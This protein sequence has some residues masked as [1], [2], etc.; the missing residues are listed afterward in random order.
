MGSPPRSTPGVRPSAG[1]ALC[2]FNGARFLQAQLDSLSA[3]DERPQQ[4]V[5]I[6]D[7]SSDGSWELLQSW[8]AAAAGQVRVE[9]NA[10]RMGVV[11]NFEK[12]LSM[13]GTD[14]VFPCDQDD[15]WYPSKVRRFINAFA[16]DPQLTLLHGDADLVGEAGDALGW[17]LFGALR[18]TAQEQEFIAQ[19]QAWKVYARRNLVTGA[20]SAFRRQLLEIST[21]FSLDWVHDEWLGFHAALVGRVALC[22]EPMMAYRLHGN[23][24]V[25]LPLPTFGWWMRS[26]LQALLRPTTARQRWRAQR[27]DTMTEVARKLCA[28]SAAIDHLSMAAA[29]ARFR[30]G[31]PRNFAER[32]AGITRGCRAGHYHAWSNGPVSM[33]H[34]L[35]I[36]W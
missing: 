35:L 4:I 17:K 6:D 25:G 36:P 32:L 10:N 20:A 30:G 31:L 3:Q 14:I 23:N 27:L 19:G 16:Q 7:G 8:A 11:R 13:L 33:L 26:T 5:V 15:V 2:V 1:V 28:P 12:A 24:A 29:H 18:V 22:P 34:D 9:R 21:P